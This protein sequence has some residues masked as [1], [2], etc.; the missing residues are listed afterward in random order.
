L[1]LPSTTLASKGLLGAGQLGIIASAVSA[2]VDASVTNFTLG[3]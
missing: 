1:S 2:V 3:P